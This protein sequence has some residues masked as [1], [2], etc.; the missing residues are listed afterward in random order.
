MPKLP[1]PVMPVLETP[2]PPPR[3]RGATRTNAVVL[4]VQELR[5]QRLV[6]LLVLP[7][8]VHG[9][10]REGRGAGVSGRETSATVCRDS[11]FK[12]PVLCIEGRTAYRAAGPSVGI[13]VGE[14]RQ[15][16]ESSAG[17]HTGRRSRT[18]CEDKD[19]GGGCRPSLV[20]T[21]AFSRSR[22]SRESGI[23]GFGFGGRRWFCLQ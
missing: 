3:P 21:R 5:V 18:K 14:A 20:G 2:S 7:L 19:R 11:E 22:E 12:M 13:G 16:W 6:R 23:G 9:G 10:R 17:K 15:R 1:P 8:P 4:R